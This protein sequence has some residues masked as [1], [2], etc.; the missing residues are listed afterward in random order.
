MRA[1]MSA[2]NGMTPN[3]SRE[4]TLRYLYKTIEADDE[5]CGVIGYSEGASAAATLILDEQERMRLAGITP[6]I[7][8]GIFFMGWP[9][10]NG[11]GVPALADEMDES[12]DVATL[13][14]VGAKGRYKHSEL[15]RHC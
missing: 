15:M 8:C 11:D 6:R 10:L 9:A 14:V 5:I 3:G 12:I 1:L 7:K 13:H 4:E 2:E